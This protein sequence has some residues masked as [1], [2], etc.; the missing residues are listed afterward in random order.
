MKNLLLLSAAALLLAGAQCSSA[1][2]EAPAKAAA[3]PDGFGAYW[4]QGKAELTSY[5]LE[6]GRYGELRKGEAV[7]VFVTED[8][9]RRKQV[10]LDDPAKAPPGDKVPVL[11]LNTSKKFLTGVYP[12]SIMTSSYT[13]LN[14]ATDP[15][16]LKV[17]T[18]VQEWCGHIFTQLNLRG[19]KYA[20]S[21]KSY[22]ESE[23]DTETTIDATLLEDELWNRIRLNPAGLPRGK[24]QL[25][26]GTVYSRLQHQPLQPVPAEL[27]LSDAP[28]GRFGSMPASAYRIAYSGTEHEVVIYFQKAFPHVILGWEETYLD[29]IA[30]QPIRLTT[31]ATRRKTI[32]LDYW[33]THANA[34]LRW[35]DSLGLGR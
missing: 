23:G 28:V 20:V 29:R 6:Q 35:R 32:Q 3:L 27:S 2:A 17:S 24:V 18:S 16:S 34:D 1:P 5:D 11:K 22:F 26:P 9:S 4:F 21:Q 14:Q 31:R 33:R 25:V 8:L 10:K 30:A 15:R 7:L 19:K 12:Y 13:P